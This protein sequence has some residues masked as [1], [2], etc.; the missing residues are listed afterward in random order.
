[1]F[2]YNG[3]YTAALK[4]AIDWASRA[5]PDLPEGFRSAWSSRKVIGLMST[6]GGGVKH[7]KAGIRNCFTVLPGEVMPDSVA[8]LEYNRF[9]EVL[10]DES[11][12]DVT[13]PAVRE[14]AAAY[15]V[16]FLAFLADTPARR[17][18]EPQ[19]SD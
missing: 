2:R 16:A 3:G 11:T 10:F 4:N 19:D 1:M 6:G 13:D 12:G 9:R 17:A 18:A 5:G 8:N 15:A 7:S 14:A